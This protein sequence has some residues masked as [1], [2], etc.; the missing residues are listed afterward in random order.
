MSV[1][2]VVTTITALASTVRSVNQKQNALLSM[3]AAI[4]SRNSMNADAEEE[5]WI[6]EQKMEAYTEYAKT[7]EELAQKEKII[8]IA[9]TSLAFISAIIFVVQIRRG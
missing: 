1:I 8:T 7:Q 9:S 4:K 6:A 2:A 5:L 3:D